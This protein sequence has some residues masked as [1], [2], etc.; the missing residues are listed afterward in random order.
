MDNIEHR[1]TETCLESINLIISTKGPFDIKP[2]TGI[3]EIRN[4]FFD[5][6]AITEVTV[7]EFLH[8]YCSGYAITPAY[9]LRN[10]A[11]IHPKTGQPR[12]APSNNSIF[13]S[14]AIFAVDIDNAKKPGEVID[15]N[16]TPANV[17]RTCD[18]YHL[19]PILICDSYS[20]RPGCRRLRVLFLLSTPVC[21]LRIRN[22]YQDKLI[23]VFDNAGYKYVDKGCS[24]ISHFFYGTTQ[25]RVRYLRPNNRVSIAVRDSIIS[26]IEKSHSNR[27]TCVIPFS[28]HSQPR[29]TDQNVD[30]QVIDMQISSPKSNKSKQSNTYHIYGM[31][32][33]AQTQDS[34]V[35]ERYRQADLIRFEVFSQHSIKDGMI[36]CEFHND[37]NPSAGI[38]TVSKG[39]NTGS[40]RYHCFVCNK[41]LSPIEYLIRKRHINKREA[42]NV[43]LRSRPEI[44][45]L[46]EFVDQ[47][48]NV[49][50]SYPEQCK[51]LRFN[52]NND[53]KYL[54]C[55]IEWSQGEGV[56]VENE[57]YFPL[58]ITE[59]QNELCARVLPYRIGTSTASVQQHLVRLVAEGFMRRVDVPQLKRIIPHAYKFGWILQQKN[60]HP[61]PTEWY[62]LR[63]DITFQDWLSHAAERAQEYR[64]AG[65]RGAQ[66]LSS[67]RHLDSGLADEIFHADRN[68]PIPEVTRKSCARF[69]EGIERLLAI[70]GW[71]IERN[72]LRA[73]RLYDGRRELRFNE[74]KRI[75]DQ[76]WPTIM[77]ELRLE[78]KVVN[79]ELRERFGIPETV[80]RNSKIL[81]KKV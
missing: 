55:L 37:S 6:S 59:M 52:I 75:L 56:V 30:V 25:N 38:F 11:D 47:L 80:K 70:Q 45:H 73:T 16:L 65:K 49:R 71:G 81:F 1:D 41:T 57:L 19:A 35:D 64:V 67:L 18:E 68:R 33:E 63:L 10:P 58:A 50:V 3:G 5:K 27:L 8:Y 15:K 32:E 9:L 2:E 60:N 78:W 22:K 4:S 72:V 28:P 77:R 51:A 21:D 24:A 14:Q 61:R 44:M 48:K 31:N 46:R 17:L 34:Q 66:T 76:C 53:D 40:E 42:L 7:E 20:S 39:P 43:L 36:C 12:I 62:A 26:D 23:Q 54:K 29:K 69:I 79:P 74:K 13:V